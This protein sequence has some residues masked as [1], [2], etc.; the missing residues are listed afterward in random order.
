[1][2][3]NTSESLKTPTYF[4]LDSLDEFGAFNPAR[5]FDLLGALIADSLLVEFNE[6]ACWRLFCD[7]FNSGIALYMQLVTQFNFASI[8]VN[9]L[10]LLICLVM[11]LLVQSSCLLNGEFAGN[12]IFHLLLLL[13]HKWD[14]IFSRLGDVSV[15]TFLRSRLSSRFW[16]LATDRCFRKRGRRVEFWTEFHA[17]NLPHLSSCHYFKVMVKL[18]PLIVWIS[19][20]LRAVTFSA[21]CWSLPYTDLL[22]VQ[23]PSGC[24]S[25]GCESVS[26]LGKDAGFLWSCK[27]RLAKVS[28][29]GQVK[30]ASKVVFISL[31]KIIH[32]STHTLMLSTTTYRSRRFL[33][34][35]TKCSLLVVTS[36]WL[37]FS[38]ER[39]CQLLHISTRMDAFT[40]ICHWKAILA[41]ICR[42]L[43][44]KIH[45][46]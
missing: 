2:L 40:L 25:L 5:V 42:S 24:R 16:L 46:Y 39:V 6:I 36:Q 14:W 17:L 12:N 37:A 18:K 38:C 45:F 23:L 33:K 7:I 32:R 3:A 22:G 41:L 35:A 30:L 4:V 26:A 13:L 15:L 11:M 29:F 9:G 8:W 1:M 20:L 34:G 28:K 10:F 31:M 27:H 44:W 21:T 19:E 43:W